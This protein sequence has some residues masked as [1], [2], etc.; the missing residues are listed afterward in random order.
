MTETMYRYIEKS[1]MFQQLNNFESYDT[2]CI[3]ELDNMKLMF[4]QDNVYCVSIDNEDLYE[5][6]NIHLVKN[7]NI[8]EIIKIFNE[9]IVKQDDLVLEDNMNLFG[10]SESRLKYTL[11]KS[12]LYENFNNNLKTTS[13]ISKFGI[14]LNRNQ[15]FEMIFSEVENINKNYK[16]NHYAVFKDDNI[17]SIYFRFVYKGEL[18]SKLKNLKDNYIEILQ[19]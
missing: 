17:F 9:L 10:H 5:K 2:V 18:G 6:L 15:L 11:D 1:D 7:P 19:I 12:K 3:P 13:D 14:N 4:D 16:Y 8:F